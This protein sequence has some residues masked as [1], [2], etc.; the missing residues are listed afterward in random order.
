MVKNTHIPYGIDATPQYPSHAKDE[1]EAWEMLDE[2]QLS[3]EKC[4]VVAPELARWLGDAIKYCDYNQSRLLHR[5]GMKRSKGRQMKDPDGWMTVGRR[6]CE[7]EEQE[8]ASLEDAIAR[9]LTENDPGG[10]SD[11]ALTRTT[12]QR[13]RNRYREIDDL[14][15]CRDEPFDN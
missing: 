7:L 11:E 4:E 3:L 1:A 6:I 5:L 15:H 10:N 13:W 12:L 8:G 9:V 14:A 2:I